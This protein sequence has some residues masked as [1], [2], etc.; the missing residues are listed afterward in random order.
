MIGDTDAFPRMPASY[1][2]RRYFV[3]F[4][5]VIRPIFKLMSVLLAGQVRLVTIQM[6]QGPQAGV[7]P[8]AGVVKRV[9]RTR[10]ER[11]RARGETAERQRAP[12]S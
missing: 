12:G 1:A 6:A 8:S 10:A 9:K 7:K 2:R 4:L 5:F 11:Y 3:R